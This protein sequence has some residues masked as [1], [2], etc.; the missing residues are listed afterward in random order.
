MARADVFIGLSVPGILSV[1]DLKRMAARPDRV[2]HGQPRAGDSKPEVAQNHVRV[3]ATGS[4]RLPKPD[5]S[6]HLS[7]SFSQRNLMV[8]HRDQYPSREIP[9]P[10]AEKENHRKY[11]EKKS[12]NT[13][14]QPEILPTSRQRQHGR[15]HGR[16][17]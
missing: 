8:Q 16:Y 5:Q 12:G 4:L 7:M 15:K 1:R 6:R 10:S 14:G 17:S 2:R 13:D 3:M 9:V 11:C